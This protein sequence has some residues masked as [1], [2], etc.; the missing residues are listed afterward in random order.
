[1]TLTLDGKGVAP[2]NAVSMW[3]FSPSNAFETASADRVRPCDLAEQRGADRPCR[4]PLRRH[5]L[6]NGGDGGD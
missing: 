1:M 5:Q 4:T 2:S 6:R 3:D